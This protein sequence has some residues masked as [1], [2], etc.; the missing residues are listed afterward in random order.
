MA[1]KQKPKKRGNPVAK[2]M[3]EFNRPQTHRDRK[4]DYRRQEKHKGSQDPFLMTRFSV[5]SFLYKCISIIMNQ[6]LIYY[7]HEDHTG[8][9]WWPVPI[10]AEVHF[11]EG[12][13]YKIYNIE[14]CAD[15]MPFRDA[16]YAALRET[17]WGMLNKTDVLMPALKNK[18][19]LS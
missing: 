13:K 1:K 14:Y 2:N 16:C 9:A 11:L 18:S 7:K 8:N 19:T 17:T 3:D 15:T 6:C 10:C 5:T 12:Y 4:N